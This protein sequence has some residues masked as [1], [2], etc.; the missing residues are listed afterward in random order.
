MRC[1]YSFLL[2]LLFCLWL[3][4]F[5]TEAK[6][7]VVIVLDNSDE[8][9]GQILSIIEEKTNH[10]L[11]SQTEK[12]RIYSY[13]PSKIDFITKYNRWLTN[14]IIVTKR[15]LDIKIIIPESYKKYIMKFM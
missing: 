12:K 14:D 7:T 9:Y 4:F 15:D 10:T 8:T 5:T 2:R 13:K 3:R 6:A 1:V 11:A